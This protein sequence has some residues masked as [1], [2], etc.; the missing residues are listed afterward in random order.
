MFALILPNITDA[1]L[2]IKR[3]VQNMQNK[4]DFTK[5]YPSSIMDSN[6]IGGIMR[7]KV[8]LAIKDLSITDFSK[9]LGCN[10]NYMSLIMHGR[11]KPGKRLAKDIMAFTQGEVDVLEEPQKIVQ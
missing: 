9:Q 11:K 8:Y 10:R 4:A 6:H 1:T 2:K 5:I 3:N 7:L